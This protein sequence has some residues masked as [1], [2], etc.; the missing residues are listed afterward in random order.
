MLIIPLLQS[1]GAERLSPFIQFLIF[2][3]GTFFF[4][5]I[6]L[7]AFTLNRKILIQCAFGLLTLVLAIDLWQPPLLVN[8]NGQLNSGVLL[9]ASS[10]D[11]VAGALAQI[12]GLT[13]IGVFIFTYI[14]TPIILLFIA[15]RLLPNFV[16]TL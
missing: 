13:G 16:K 4:F 1:M 6:F 7:K 2:N 12:I 9:G 5:Q 8:Y 11:Y 10:T 3:T 15:S 14:I